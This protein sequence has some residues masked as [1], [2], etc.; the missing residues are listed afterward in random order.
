MKLNAIASAFVLTMGMAAS[1][2]YAAD[3]GSGE[4]RFVGSIIDAACSINPDSTN[5]EVD[6]GQIAAVQL[7]GK[8][9]STPRNFEIKLENCALNE[10]KSAPSVAVTFGGAQAVAGEDTW[11]GMTGDSN[12]AG[13]VITDASSN[14]IPVNGTSAARELIVGDNTLAFS[15]YLQGIADEIRPGDFTAVTNFTMAYE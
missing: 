7:Q 8:G 3:G 10:D 11:F 1:S 5:Q 12:G 9:T 13:V 4:I 15:A 6:L 14:I 2:V